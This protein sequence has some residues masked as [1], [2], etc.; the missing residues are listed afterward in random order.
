MKERAGRDAELVPA[1]VAVPLRA[2]GEPQQAR[3]LTAARALDSVGPAKL[4]QVL[5]AFVLE[6]VVIQPMVEVEPRGNLGTE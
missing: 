4:A 6:G 3:A 2:G 1:L 5:A